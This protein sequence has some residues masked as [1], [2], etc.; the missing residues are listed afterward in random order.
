MHDDSTDV[1]PLVPRLVDLSRILSRK[2]SRDDEMYQRRS[3]LDVLRSVSRPHASEGRERLRCYCLEEAPYVRICLQL[4]DVDLEG[5]GS[6]L[7][8]STMHTPVEENSQAYNRF[9]R[10]KVRPVEVVVGISNLLRLESI[11]GRPETTLDG[12]RESLILRL[13][14]YERPGE[15]HNAF[16]Y[17]LVTSTT[18][19]FAVVLKDQ[20]ALKVLRDVIS[21]RDPL[22]SM[23]Q[24]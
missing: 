2:L 21:L 6:Y 1:A 22:N 4:A 8:S 15:I 23:S 13:I 18:H 9:R 14:L 7:S 24:A 11:I 16:S 20:R 19:I 12:K 10:G 5:L 3:P 17:F